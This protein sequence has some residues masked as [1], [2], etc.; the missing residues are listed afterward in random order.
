[1]WPFSQVQSTPQPPA[2]LEDKA[3]FTTAN[4]AGGGEAALYFP[5]VEPAYDASYFPTVNQQ[6]QLLIHWDRPPADQPPDGWWADRTVWQQQQTKI[7]HQRGVAWEVQTGQTPRAEDSP[8]A[9]APKINRAT[10][11]LSVSDYRFNRPFGQG[12]E[13]ELNGLHMSMATNQQAYLIGEMNPSPVYTNTYRIDPPTN[14]A[15]SLFTDDT[16]SATFVTY[17]SGESFSASY[18]L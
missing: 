17:G 13:Y 10:A 4:G 11:D 8:Y 9:K 6:D 16:G 7:E 15:G 18:A 14:D 3:D 2:G 12:T 1:M 5:G